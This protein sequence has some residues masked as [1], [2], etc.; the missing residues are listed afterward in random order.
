M[1]LQK[2]VIFPVLAADTIVVL[3]EEIFGKPE[4]ESDAIS[5]LMKFSGKTHSVI[6]GVTIGIV[7]SDKTEF[8]TVSAESKVGFAKLGLN[9]CK[10]YCKTNEP[11]DKAG[12]YGIQGYGSAFI[13]EIKGSY[14]NIVGLP[15]HEVAELLKKL[16]I[17]Y[18][19]KK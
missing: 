15:I 8:H 12:S 17:P 1:N 13:K 18:W 7:L 6:T 3:E 2:K 4:S 5:M 10:E 19:N 14:S 11:F 16:K 9:D